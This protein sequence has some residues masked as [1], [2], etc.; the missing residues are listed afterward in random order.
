MG[1]YLA[2]EL[3]QLT[4]QEMVY[5]KEVQGIEKNKGLQKQ[6]ESVE[7]TG[8]KG[9]VFDNETKEIAGY[10]QVKEENEKDK[11]LVIDATAFALQSVAGRKRKW[12][13]KV[14]KSSSKLQWSK[15]P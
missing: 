15:K 2:E 13:M 7:Y 12:K 8:L 14:K 4:D 5:M 11:T 9:L 10:K 6:V 1:H 3:K